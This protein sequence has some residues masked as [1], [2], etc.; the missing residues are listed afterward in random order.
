MDEPRNPVIVGAFCA[1]LFSALVAVYE[2]IG[3]AAPLTYGTAA[4]G[5][6]FVGGVAAIL[7]NLLPPKR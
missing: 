2:V 6:M 4:V 5:G 3:I 1:A 7:A